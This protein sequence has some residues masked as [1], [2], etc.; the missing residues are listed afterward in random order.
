MNAVF[1]HK[2]CVLRDSHA[3]LQAPAETWRL[4]PATLEA[5]RFLGTEETLVF[6]YDP[7][8]AAGAPGEHRG[9]GLEALVKQVEAAGGR[10]DGLIS[11]GHHPEEPCKCW[12]DSP[13]LL[14]MAAAEFS[15]RLNECYVLAD[16]EQDVCAACAV[17][18]RPLLVLCERSI[19][20]VLGDLPRYKSFPIATDLT[21][22]VS[23]IAVEE[24]INRQLG[25]PRSEPTA[26]PNT[27]S[28]YG[29]S[30]ALPTLQVTSVL[31]QG[32]Q[33][34]MRKARVQLRDMGRWLTFL[35]LGAVGLS[36]GIAY[37]LTHLYR[38][39]PFPEFVYWI[40]LQFIPR[41]VRGGLFIA[42]GA[43]ALALA[44]RSFYRST[45]RFWRRQRP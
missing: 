30:A 41:P 3:D 6:V 43:G 45:A 33:T 4:T 28:L 2:N 42:W 26:P 21:R 22:A 24:E 15:L 13:G 39:Q 38:S 23:Y 14:W 29:P 19:G 25:H 20:E 17:G 44:V 36:L 8:P 11:C 31:A 7:A 37:M 1:I 18:A 9:N 27:E 32:L 5:I 34:R 16:S 10:V 35:V 40:T 12:G